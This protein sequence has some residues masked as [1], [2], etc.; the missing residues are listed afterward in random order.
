MAIN[1]K[2]NIKFL[3]HLPHKFISSVKYNTFKIRYFYS[4]LTNNDN[5]TELKTTLE[6][7]P[8]NILQLKVGVLL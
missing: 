7:Q 5:I 1:G 2:F 8:E 6:K 3:T 4:H